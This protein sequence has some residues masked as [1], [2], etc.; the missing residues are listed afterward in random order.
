MNATAIGNQFGVLT[1]NQNTTSHY[2]RAIYQFTVH[3]AQTLFQDLDISRTM[4]IAK[5]LLNVLTLEF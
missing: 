3:L 2:I 4:T 1:E 5:K